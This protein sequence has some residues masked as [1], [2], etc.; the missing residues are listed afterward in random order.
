MSIFTQ[1]R[2]SFETSHA[3][4][5]RLQSFKKQ[6][7]NCCYACYLIFVMINYG[8]TQKIKEVIRCLLHKIKNNSN[9]QIQR[10]IGKYYT[11]LIL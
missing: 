5:Y 3:N 8:Y 11:L 10:I 7:T 2:V 1:Y 4:W 6:F 9:K